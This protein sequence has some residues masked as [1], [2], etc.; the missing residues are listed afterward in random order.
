MVCGFCRGYAKYGRCKDVCF[1]LLDFER[2]AL[3]KC[4][5]AMVSA[6]VH[7]ASAGLSARCNGG[8]RASRRSM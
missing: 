4:L 2:L 6:L 7:R 5:R 1:L 3:S 8:G